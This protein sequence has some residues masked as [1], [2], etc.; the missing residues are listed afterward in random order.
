MPS[1]FP[2]RSHAG[3]SSHS[4]ATLLV[5]GEPPP[6]LLCPESTASMHL[7][8]SLVQPS[9]ALPYS[10]QLDRRWSSP[11]HS[12]LERHR[13]GVFPRWSSRFLFHYQSPST[14][15]RWWDLTAHHHASAPLCQ[16]TTI[17]APLPLPRAVIA[18]WCRST[19]GERASCTRPHKHSGRRCYGLPCTWSR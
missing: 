10:N 18:S 3:C 14:P 5:Y 11:P 7:P 8:L 16:G 4:R 9:R 12:V 19:V 1:L 13:A 2:H 17:R 6:P 15:Y